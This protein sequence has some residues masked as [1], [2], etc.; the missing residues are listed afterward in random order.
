MS[1]NNDNFLIERDDIE[2]AQNI[3]GAIS[4]KETRKR[5]AANV[6][7]AELS[8]R[9]FKDVDVDTVSGIHNCASVLNN[10]DISDIYV[11]DNYIDVRIYFNENEL[12]VPKSHFDLDI[13][14]VAYMFIKVSDDLSSGQVAGFVFPED[15]NIDNDVDGYYFVNEET[16]VSFYDVESRL[17]TIEDEG[18]DS[19]FEKEIYDFLDG[20]D[21]KLKEFYKNLVLSVSAREYL[22]NTSKAYVIYNKIS[23]SSNKNTDEEYV[24]TFESQQNNLKNDEAVEE[25]NLAVLDEAESFELVADEDSPLDLVDENS[26]FDDGLLDEPA[27]MN[28]LE[29]SEGDELLIADEPE[30]SILE[31]SEENETDSGLTEDAGLYSVEDNIENATPVEVEPDDAEAEENILPEAEDIE[32]VEVLDDEETP[33]EQVLDIVQDEEINAQED[34]VTEPLK[35][36][37]DEFDELSKFDYSTEIEPSIT[38]IENG[39]SSIQDDITEEMLDTADKIRQEENAQAQAVYTESEE[40]IDKLFENPHAAVN[41]TKKKK[42]AMLP[43]LGFLV[44][45]GALGYYGY[46][47]YFAQMPDLTATAD[48]SANSSSPKSSVKSEKQAEKTA[49]PIETVENNT[50][51]SKT[52][53]AVSVSIPAIE[54][55]L[56]ASIDVSELT[57]NWEVPLSYANNTTAKRYFVKIGKVLQ[58]N[59]KMELLML[60]SPPITNKISVELGFDS[61]TK[62][63]TINKIVDSS[64]VETVDRVVQDTVKKVLGMNMNMNMSVFSTLQGNPILIIKL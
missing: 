4:D 10:I 26:E 19:G 17:T 35:E 51:Q 21:V 63:F 31:V 54:K 14:P 29:E 44:I 59:L 22:L 46:T 38:S 36:A 56:N 48:M 53:D 52:N 27:D 11:K 5:A 7:A 55:D 34:V 24:Y 28:M 50:V 60:S 45:A 13:L 9:Y 47:K 58:L 62:K 12:C 6:L 16:L 23:S 8:K 64:G 30:N 57:V 41:T 2:I 37:V 42:G 40:Q 39:T 61:S 43:F 49:M 3:S 32:S 18:Y 25:E 1:V 20:K 15:V 33:N